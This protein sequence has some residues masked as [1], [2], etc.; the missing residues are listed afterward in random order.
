MKK[1]LM[2]SLAVVLA[3][4]CL[5]GCGN[6]IPEMTEEQ[7]ALVV[8]FAANELLKY[9]T[10]HESKLTV[11]E[12]EQDAPAE[13]TVTEETP[14]SE[15]SPVASEETLETVSEE[16]TA[17]SE[18]GVAT[19]EVTIVDNTTGE[20][21]LQNVSIESFLQL[22]GAEITYTG[23]ET[24]VSYPSVEAE[25][26]IYFFMSATAGNR[27]LILK[28]NVENVSGA[29]LVLDMAKTGTKYK[30]IVDGVEKNALTTML[31][32]DMAYYQGTVA[33]EESVELVL[34]CEIQEEQASAVENLQLKMK[35]VDNSATISLN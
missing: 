29:E 22:E 26:E 32:D 5:T 23:Y 14:M 15:E 17:E 3:G 27:L 34:V 25:E 8:E 21:Q 20:A 16:Q 7:Q 9:D 18:E 2:S 11:L 10:N 13:E 35:N 4:I 19:D 31:L 33:A 6:A 30:I 12:L 1:G 28:F 24:D